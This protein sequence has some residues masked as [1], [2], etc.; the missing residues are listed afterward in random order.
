MTWAGAAIVV[1]LIVAAIGA[2]LLAVRAWRAGWIGD[3]ALVLLSIA[4]FPAI[5][6][7]FGLILHVPMPLLVL[8][9]LISLV[10]GL[11]LSRVIRDVAGEQSTRR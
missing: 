4:R 1:V 5:A 9:T 2:R 3:G 6:L 8:L 7:A 10:P 11:L